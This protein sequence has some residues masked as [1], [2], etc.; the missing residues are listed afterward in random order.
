MKYPA[1]LTLVVAAAAYPAFA[2]SARFPVGER[3]EYRLDYTSRTRTDFRPLFGDTSRS[4]HPG[5][6]H[7]VIA[8]LHT[9][10]TQTVVSSSDSDVVAVVALQNPSVKLVLNDIPA[11]DAVDQ[12]KE[13]FAKPVFV[14]LQRDGRIAGIKIDSASGELAASFIENV[15][16][17]TQFAVADGFQ[18]RDRWSVLEENQAGDYIAAYRR[19]GTRSFQKTFLPYMPQVQIVPAGG[20]VSQV[21][22]ESGSITAVLDKTGQVASLTGSP[23]H[24]TS[25]AGKRIG[26]SDAHIEMKRLSAATVS[27]QELA[28][29]QQLSQQQK[30]QRLFDPGWEPRGDTA[31]HRTQL[32]DETFSGLKHR[33]TSTADSSTTDLYLD[34]KALLFLH[35]DE[36]AEVSDILV[37]AKANSQAMLILSEALSST[38]G[39]DAQAA[40]RRVINARRT[41]WP[42]LASL[43]PALGSVKEPTGESVD[44]MLDLGSNARDERIASTARL[45]AGTMA[46]RLRSRDP[47]RAAAVVARLTGDSTALRNA[48]AERKQDW[49]SATAT[50]VAPGVTY[51]RLVQNSGPWRINVLEVNLA[52][53]GLSIRAMKAKDSFVGKETVSSMASRYKGPGK[54]IGAINGDFFNIRTGE[55][56]NNVVIEGDLFKGTTVSDSPYDKFNAVHSQIEVDWKNHAYIE[57][58]KLNAFLGSHHL[59]GIN[60]LPPDTSVMALY[61]SAM[62]DSSLPDTLG[63]HPTLLSLSLVRKKGDSTWYRAAGNVIEGGRHA[64]NGGAMLAA[65]GTRRD[66]VRAIARQHGTLKLV[67][68]FT[69]DHGHIRTVVGG[70][71]VIVNDGKSVAEYADVVE[72]TFPKFSVQRHP[73]TGVGIS[74]DGKT[75]Y[76]MTVDGRRESEGGMSLVELAQTMLRLGA[77]EAMNFD[78]GGSTT[79]VVDGKVVNRPSDATGERA[80]G[81]ALLIV[82]DR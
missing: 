28:A 50:T 20:T 27:T 79:M 18:N 7:D 21:V 15:L 78:G 74:K 76:L 63:R 71:P 3:T 75:L 10:I 25:V 45:A 64:L 24:E 72:G 34:F 9:V 73:R 39:P 81:S 61:T 5:L 52:Q 33:L 59:D 66:E 49:D 57:R 44:L 70:W 80:V 56:E 62:G 30:W 53:P 6:T 29:L 37:N 23:H 17:V 12:L 35:P 65:T 54:V 2:Q 8:E 41:E 82:L 42:A 48:G 60:Y 16:G 55:S 77:Y 58:L 1:A 13:G 68:G 14:R 11:N 46:M 4:A 36:S 38:G 19:T 40:L 22:T 31:I 32:G 47:L 43:I 69:P 51:K 26:V 67:Q